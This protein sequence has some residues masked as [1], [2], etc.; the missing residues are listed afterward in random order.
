MKDISSLSCPV[1]LDHSRIVFEAE[2]NVKG[3]KP[4]IQEETKKPQLLT[5]E[6]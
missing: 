1:W 3:T 2:W 6:Q 4:F 5:S